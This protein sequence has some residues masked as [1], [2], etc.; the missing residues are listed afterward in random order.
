MKLSVVSIL[1]KALLLSAALL[2]VN[3]SGNKDDFENFEASDLAVNY[4]A[5]YI[6]ALVSGVA[7][8][9]PDAE[10][11]VS[12]VSGGV[13]VYRIIYK[14]DAGGRDFSASGLVC[15]PEGGGSSPVLCFLNGTN[16][17][18][19]YAPSNFFSDTRYQLIE[20]AASTGY[21]VVIP[22]YP[23][24]GA[25]DDIVH[26]YL[27]EDITVESV[28]DMLRAV[29]QGIGSI[30]SGAAVKNEYY[31]AGY[32]QGGWAA[33]ALH[34][35]LENDMAAEFDLR[36]SVCGA[37]PY[38]IDWLLED[39]S[40]AETYEMPVYPAYIIH[41]YSYWGEFSN[42]VTD[43]IKEPYSSSLPTL[44]NGTNDFST[45]N[46]QLTT[47][48]AGLFN[49]SFL[50]GYLTSP[51]YSSVRDALRRNSIEPW[52]TEKY[53]FMF[54]GSADTDVFPGVTDYFYNALIEAGSS[55]EK[56]KKVSYEDLGHGDAL[57]PGLIEGL[58]FLDSIRN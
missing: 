23:G 58:I 43:I 51:N 11:L 55:T 47:S 33:M 2:M 54:H 36:G 42:P 52:K 14:T 22:D 48:V 3:C 7:A 20:L 50:S 6:S 25:S 18:N 1:N 57:I 24:F 35:A 46:S 8:Y 5:A 30:Q 56:V 44:F 34:R 31:L 19:D 45:I 49:A 21:I 15:V 41:A 12:R 40:K 4:S 27:I 17:V 29:K 28:A 39:I 32:S 53:L 38:D 37:G 10:E 9:Y 26:P 16:T 13:N